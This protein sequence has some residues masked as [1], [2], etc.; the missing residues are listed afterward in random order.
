MNDIQMENLLAQMRTMAA[1]A[2]GG[3]KAAASEPS[4]DFGHLLRSSIDRVNELQRH[5]REAKQAFQTGES[6]MSLAEVMLTAEKASIAFQTLLQVRNKVIRAYQDV[7]SM[8]L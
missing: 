4:A 6:D 3:E 8:P 7:I 5:S 1:Q 2:R